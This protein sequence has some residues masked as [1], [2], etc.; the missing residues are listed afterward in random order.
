MEHKF[1]LADGSRYLLSH[2][3]FEQS[4]DLFLSFSFIGALQIF[5]EKILSLHIQSDSTKRS[6]RKQN[7]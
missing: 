1:D 7:E 2:T 3:L 5:S 4:F 6:E